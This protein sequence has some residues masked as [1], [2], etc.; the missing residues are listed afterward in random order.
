MSRWVK[1]KTLGYHPSEGNQ[2]E[3]WNKCIYAI[4]TKQGCKTKEVQYGKC[5]PHA[6]AP[7]YIA[8][9]QEIITDQNY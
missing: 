8:I 9:V 1:N 7:S 6:P 3:E 5:A 2:E 4:D